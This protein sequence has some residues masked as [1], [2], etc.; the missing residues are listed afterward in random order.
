MLEVPSYHKQL[1]QTSITVAQ[2]KFLKNGRN[3]TMLISFLCDNTDYENTDSL[4]QKQEL[5]L[6]L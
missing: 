6:I 3:K 4:Y 5:I 1:L 2:E